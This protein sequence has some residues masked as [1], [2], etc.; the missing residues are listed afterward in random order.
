[1]PHPT[2]R[3]PRCPRPPLRGSKL[4]HHVRQPLQ[5]RR[6]HLRSL[7][8]HQHVVLVVH[9]QRT[10]S[11][12]HR[13]LVPVLDRLSRPLRV[14]RLHRQQRPRLAPQERVRPL[15]RRRRHHVGHKRRR[16][17]LPPIPVTQAR[18]RGGTRT[19]PRSTPTPRT[20][21]PPAPTP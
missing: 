18:A 12:V 15:V 1:S 7:R 2:P 5:P 14:H 9:A 3:L 10:V 21:A 8:R 11:R 13:P 6:Q 4:P 16:V 17:Q 19:P 20:A